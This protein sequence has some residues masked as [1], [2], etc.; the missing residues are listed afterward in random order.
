MVKDPFIKKCLEV[1]GENLVLAKLWLRGYVSFLTPRNYPKIDIVAYNPIKNNIQV[2]IQVKTTEENMFTL[3]KLEKDNLETK[4]KEPYIFVHVSKDRK[5]I[6]F[7]IVPPSDI[8]KLILQSWD[9]YVKTSKHRKPLA[10][11]EEQPQGILLD[12]LQDYQDKWENL[13]L[14]VI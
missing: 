8:S 3:G 14:E 9:R 5:N 1:G 10:P 11:F 7:F 2:G 13:G 4:F 12:Q 6:R